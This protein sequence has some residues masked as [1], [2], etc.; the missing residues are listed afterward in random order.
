MAL[1]YIRASNY[2]VREATRD[3]S[4]TGCRVKF[5][6]KLFLKPFLV[7]PLALLWRDAAA[8]VDRK[9]VQRIADDRQWIAHE[10][11]R[12]PRAPLVGLY[13]A[14]LDSDREVGSENTLDARPLNNL[15][16]QYHAE[17][18]Y[19][20]A[21]SLYKRGLLLLEQS[22]GPD[23][24]ALGAALGNLAALYQDQARYAEAERLCQRSIVILEKAFGP[25]HPQLAVALHNL[26]L[27][28]EH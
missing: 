22:L 13:L 4:K 2:Q 6:S 15:A 12:Q 10:T 7:I 8:A 19:A 26:A 1:I 23:H 20:E 17:G 16:L 28:Y 11:R 24:P 21:E 3:R 5:K 25:D 27:V 9:P 14:A 18:R